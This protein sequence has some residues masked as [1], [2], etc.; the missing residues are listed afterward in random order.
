MKQHTTKHL[1]DYRPYPFTLSTIDLRFELHPEQT[2]VTA[3]T[4]IKRNA[5][6][7]LN[8]DS[9]SALELNG[10]Y[11]TLVSVKINDRFLTETEYTYDGHLLQIRE[12]PD[13]FTLE[14]ETLINPRDNTALEGLYLSSGNY[15]TQ[16][17]AEGFRR[18]TCYPDRPD[19]LAVFTTTVIGPKDSCPVLLANGNLTDQGELADGRHF[20]T[21]HDPFPKPSYLFALV[22][23][24]LTCIEDHFTTISGRQVTL[25]IYVEHRNK[26]K[27]QHAM[28]SLKNSMRWDEQTFGREY[29]LDTYMIVAVDDFNM[30]AMENKGLN[31][32]NSKYVLARPETATDTDYANIEGVIGHEYFHNWSG[33]RVTCRDW[34][35]L[36]LKEGLT[37]FRDQEFSADMGSRA[38]KRIHEADI[39]RSFQFREDSGP[40][41]HPVRPA[42]YVEINNFYTLTVYNKGAEVIRMLH[43]LLGP[44]DFRK[45]MD[46]YFER[47]DGQA[48]TC[49]DFIQAM[50]DAQAGETTLDFEHFKRWYSQAGTPTI[51]VAQNYDP[52]SQ[53]Y[54]LSVQQTCPATPNQESEEKE[55]FLLPLRIGLLDS[56][57]QD[58]GLHLRDEGRSNGTLVLHQEKQQFHFT[59][60]EEKPVLSLNRNFAAPINIVSD[61]GEEELAFLMAHDNDPFT[62]WDAGQQL[63]LRYL[64]A[65]IDAWQQGKKLTVPAL[66]HQAFDRLLCDEK[67]DPA[68]LASA[69]TLPSETWISQQLKIIEPEAVHVSRQS[70]RY[71]LSWQ[72]RD[73]LYENYYTLGTEE[74]YQYSAEEAARRALRNCCLGYLLIPEPDEPMPEEI[75]KV[76]VEQY[77]QADNMTDA[78]AALRTV[79]NADRAAGDELLADFYSHWQT[80][81]LV[82]DK[83]L[84]LQATCPLPDTLQRVQELMQHPAFSMKNPNKVRAL[85]GAFCGNQHQFH[86]KDGKG[87]TFLVDCITELDPMNPQV[88]ARMV[89]PLTRWKQYD[90]HRQQLMKAALERIADLPGLSRDTG[91]IVE[92]S[93]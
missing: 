52:A 23:G 73:T 5:L 7:E 81:P 30:G 8:R 38:V 42:S 77:H 53:E 71:Q 90:Q 56:K 72:H 80:D 76:G 46:L 89:S 47:H 40:M 66:F 88:A 86:A 31:I 62:R 54:I 22:A 64:L 55:P 25:H 3:R 19:V 29:D 67:T 37:V 69:L 87:Y 58:M 20:A 6:N 10:E 27:C 78:L 61:L 75:L 4:T 51:T 57:G 68:F 33:N 18:I 15:C 59:G 91:E 48:V 24:D 83:W 12:V 92:K 84:T 39:M 63:G 43:T 32:F 14:I 93:L 28:E 45:G 41:A 16:C 85:V 50:Q 34:F 1:K 17:E 21:W 65:G 36:S 82:M 2:R 9:R 26:E 44:K 79:V 11:L 49:D 74:P 70:F 13:Q 60:I 35:Q